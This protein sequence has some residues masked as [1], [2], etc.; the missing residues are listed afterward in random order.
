MH[1]LCNLQL[2]YSKDLNLDSFFKVNNVDISSRLLMRLDLDVMI[3]LFAQL[4]YINS[5]LNKL[6]GLH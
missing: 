4:V 1:C 6:F 3:N 2:A 5:N